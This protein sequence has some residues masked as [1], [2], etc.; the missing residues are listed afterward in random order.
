MKAGTDSYIDDIV[1]N[2]NVVS[3]E[4]AAE[5]LARYGLQC[6]PLSE[7][8]VR[9]SVLQHTC[10]ECGINISLRL[11]SSAEN[12]ADKLTRIPKS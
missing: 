5:L 2:Q 1:V 10:Q 4:R 9:L 8:L 11:V 6:K 3:V 12:K 7:V